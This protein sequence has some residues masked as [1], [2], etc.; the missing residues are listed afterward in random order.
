MAD[1]IQAYLSASGMVLLPR[2][3]TDEM[4]FHTLVAGYL[5]SGASGDEALYL[6]KDKMDNDSYPALS[7]A[8]YVAMIAAFPDPFT[9]TPTKPS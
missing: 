1:S 7:D 9:T 2:K 8:Q 5:A 4:K 6:A 3:A